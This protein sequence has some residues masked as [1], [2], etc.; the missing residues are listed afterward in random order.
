MRHSM[1]PRLPPKQLM[2]DSLLEERR[3]GLQR[4]LRIIA[5]HPVL[6]VDPLFVAFLAD[7][8]ADH[9]EHLRNLAAREPDEFAQL[10]ENVTLP[11]E[12]QGRLAASRETMRSMLIGVTKLKRLAEQ[13]ASRT[14]AQAKDVA[15]MSTILRL[16]GEVAACT[17]MAQG[18]AD[19]AALS[20]RCAQHQQSAIGERFD[21][22]M[23][24]LLSHNDLCDRVEKGIVSEHQKA[25]SK[26]LN[27]N[28]QRIK[29]V[30][31]GTAV[32]MCCAFVR[33]SA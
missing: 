30:I 12:D 7:N 6:C 5:K 32:S 24:I 3:R 18:F 25:M 1:I 27:L 28:K 16:A 29:G 26:M 15:E 13:Q 17:D 20:E 33:K 19:V 2:L 8:S 23:D 10:S 9:Q 11:L 21:L 14:L 4:W 31:R 22:L